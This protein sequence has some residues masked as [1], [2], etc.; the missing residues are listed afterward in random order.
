M[1]SPRVVRCAM[2]YLK[3]H[4]RRSRSRERHHAS[5]SSVGRIFTTCNQGWSYHRRI[6]HLRSHHSSS[7]LCRIDHA[8]LYHASTR[9]CKNSMCITVSAVCKIKLSI[10]FFLALVAYFLVVPTVDS[11]Q[12]HHCRLLHH[13]HYPYEPCRI[14]PITLSWE[15]RHC[16]QPWNLA[17]WQNGM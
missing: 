9:C 12:H 7:A 4:D 1:M 15:C 3:F 11:Q 6:S 2:M 13:H 17:H 14:Y 10:V 8:G 16:H 5:R